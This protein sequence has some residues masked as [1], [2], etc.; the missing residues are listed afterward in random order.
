[1]RVWEIP[2]SPAG[3]ESVHRAERPEPKP[4]PSDVVVRIR[5]ASLNYR[6]HAILVGTYRYGLDRDTIPC[7]DGAGE[8]VAVGASVSR[9]KVGDRVIP[10]FF[11]LWIDGPPPKNRKALGAPLDGTLAEYISLHEDGWV[12]I[13]DSLSFEEAATLT[14]AGPT[15]WNALMTV[16]ARTKPGDTV[17]CLGTGGVSMFALQFARAAGARVIVTSSS[18]AKIER[19]R[20]FGAFG[21]VNYKTHPEWEKDVLALTGG[22]GV[23]CVIENGGI[24][25]LA[26]SFQCV[27]WGGKIALI[28]VLAGPQGNANPH[29]LM[30]KSASL[31]GIGV[32]SRAS[33]EQLIQA[34][35]IN[36]IKPVIDRVFPFDRAL[37]AFRL[38]A[39]GDFLGKIVI[40]V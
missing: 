21:G 4:G 20:G 17:L 31:H 7:S 15:A 35:E 36:R 9:F 13:P 38:Q 16:G 39:S 19:A 3:V 25:T 22:R 18:D 24:G 29:D 10:T 32:G 5:A 2:K 34:I 37:D 8:V 11:Q 14:C 26:R 6:D 33:L 30:F 12:A 28:G 1:M 40:T 27:G 23:D